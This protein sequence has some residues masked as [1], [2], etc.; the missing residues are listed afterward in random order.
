MKN[1]TDIKVVLFDKKAPDNEITAKLHGLKELTFI[2]YD[3]EKDLEG[4]IR[5]L[6]NKGRRSK[7]V[8][9]LKEFLGRFFQHCPGSPGVI[10]CNYRV[11]NTCFNCFYNC[12][13]CF[14]NSY[15]NAFGIVQ[16][17]NT[18]NI[19]KEID[20]FLDG[21]D[22]ELIYRI[23]SGEFTDS[24]MMDE[25]SGIGKKLIERYSASPNVMIEL[26]TKSDNIGHLL[27]IKNMGNAVLAWSLSTERN[28]SEYEMDSAPVHAR[29]NAARKACDAG[30]NLAFHF[31]PIIIYDRWEDDYK[32]LIGELF[33]GIDPGRVV[34]ISMGC[35]RYSPG[36]KDVIRNKFPDEDM[37]AQEMFPGIDGKFRYLKNKRVDIYKKMK[38]YIN[39]F[40][41]KPFLYLCMESGD[42]WETVFNRRYSSSEML[43]KDFS[44]HLKK[45]FT[46]EGNIK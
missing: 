37:T 34:W 10:C 15:L 17:T 9:I 3:D 13:Y 28:V 11:I 35:F 8:L 36:F 4:K 27:Q 32:N 46:L 31:D 40:T 14:L 20:A 5:E 16:F 30:Y 33:A 23:G 39:C 7:E 25:V 21:A 19:F 45:N 44:A 12:A 24:L 6:Q 18:E 43:E 22:R 42:V 29:I 41:E 1:I 38:G 2:G 26:K